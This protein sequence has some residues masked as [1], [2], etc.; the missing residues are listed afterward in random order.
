MMVTCVSAAAS[1]ERAQFTSKS[2]DADLVRYTVCMEGMFSRLGWFS[3]VAIAIAYALYLIVGSI[4]NAEASG[5]H[6]PVLIRDAVQANVHQLSGMI[7]VPTSCDELSVT[8]QTISPTNYALVFETWRE[9]SIACTSDATPRPF[10]VTVFAPATGVYFSA[11]LN[12][13]AVPIAVVP[14]LTARGE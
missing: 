10:Q 7:M 8:K 6:A 3:V 9:P 1:L 2:C 12:G 4:V 11:T 13:I 5:A 14:V